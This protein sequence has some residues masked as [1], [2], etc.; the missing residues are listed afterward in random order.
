MMNGEIVYKSSQTLTERVRA[1]GE[2]R[3]GGVGGSSSTMLL[4]QVQNRNLYP[5]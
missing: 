3:G 4:E 5:I 1:V 2:E